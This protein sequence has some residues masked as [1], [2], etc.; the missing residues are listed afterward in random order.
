MEEKEVL[1]EEVQEE[2]EVQDTFNTDALDVLVNGEDCTI[3]NQVINFIILLQ[4]VVIVNVYKVVQ[5]MQVVMYLL[6]V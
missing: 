4:E 3:E 1:T 5:Q 2:M 6:T